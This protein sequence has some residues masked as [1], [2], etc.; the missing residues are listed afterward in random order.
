GNYLIWERSHSM[1]I[2]LKSFREVDLMATIFDVAKKAGVSKSTV[3]RVLN[4]GPVSERNRRAVEA[5]MEQLGYRPNA[6][7]Q[8]LVTK[9]SRIIGFVITDVAD[10]YYSEIIRGVDA[11]LNKHGYQLLLCGTSWDTKREISYVN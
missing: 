4:G 2:S 11:C 1:L 5:A 3:S 6:A 9:R 10:P 7:A 8:G